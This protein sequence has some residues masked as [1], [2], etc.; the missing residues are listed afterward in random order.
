LDRCGQRA[1]AL[2]EFERCRRVLNEDLGIDPSAQ[3]QAL[4]KRI[5]DEVAPTLPGAP[6]EA[7]GF[8]SK[9]RLPVPL[10]ALIGRERES[11]QLLELLRREDVRLVTLMGSPGIGKTRLAVAAAGELAAE[12]GENIYFLSLAAL[13]SPGLMLTA[14]AQALGRSESGHLTPFDR[15]VQT[16]Q[17][18]R[19][20]L[21]L[22]TFEQVLDAAPA[23][24]E[25]LQACPRLKILVTARA[26]LHLRGEQRFML[27]PLAL[28]DPFC[29]S[30]PE[31]L[32]ASPAV[33]LFVERAQAV[34]PEFRL[35]TRNGKAVA[36]ICMRLDGLPLAIE[37]AAAA[38]RLM[39]PQRLL[40]RLS[41]TSGS[42]LRLLNGPVRDDAIHHQ[43]LRQ[44]FQWSYNLLEDSA[45]R[46]FARLGVFVSGCTLEAIDAICNVGDIPP[47]S[48]EGIALLLDNCLVQ[49]VE[50]PDGEYRFTM[51]ST[52]REFALDRLAA[53]GE[54]DTLRQRHAD[55]YLAY[56]RLTENELSV[57]DEVAWLERV[58]WE[59]D[60]LRAA[61][62]W[63]MGASP[64]QALSL[65]VALFPFWHVRSY[66]NEG[67][68]YLE[69][70]LGHNL[71]PSALRGR[72]LAAAGL[73][74]QRQ[75]D[76]RQAENLTSESV[77]LYRQLEDQPGLAY[78][79]NNQA[80][81]RMS[82]GENAQA[83]RLAEESLA[84][85]QKLEDVLGI[86]RAQMI[87][88]QIALNEDRLD[89]A[90]QALETSLD[91]WRRRGDSKNAILC[92]IN[93]GRVSMVK[94]SYPQA[95][96][97]IEES[98]SL[99]RKIKDPHWEMVG[100][101]NLAEITLCQGAFSQ[102]E[103]LLA[104]CLDQARRLGDRYFE[105]VTL[106]R[107]GLVS[108]SRGPQG[109]SQTAHLLQDSLDVGRR[110]GSKWI[111][112]DALAHLGYADL[113]NGAYPEADR[114][115]KQS[116]LL[117]S[118]QGECSHV[119]LNMERLAIASLRQAHCELAARLLAAASA[120]RAAHGEPLP[121]VYCAEQQLA[122]D[123][124][125]AQLGE[126]AW[127]QA[128]MEGQAMSLDQALGLI[129]QG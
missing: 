67:R 8:S 23:L 3:T 30:D 65:A 90:R 2:A 31:L 22:D 45:Q 68:R 88:G 12:F 103:P 70:A 129:S 40:E 108:L 106:S 33:K 114:Q 51:L 43:T 55:Y 96:A 107:Q 122:V 80:I 121:P 79:L 100:L 73:L 60:N 117:F 34:L 11:A 105:A 82:V 14:I 57:Q 44:A 46:L 17:S 26:P 99:S 119:V 93:L 61:L 98:L 18:V 75:G 24:S 25:I 15:L 128:W 39:S 5:H 85:C 118:E 63:T 110:T 21:I 113:L 127:T 104:G 126:G 87:S 16:F 101:W 97:L 41:G 71:M 48:V 50:S 58:E 1:A 94:G 62:D 123:Q 38:V 77:S 7:A 120:W 37:L 35:T 76:F 42:S 92:L 28:P 6:L 66:L 52:L 53:G 20:M 36:A 83:L 27:Y 47:G 111:V 91:F 59:L 69:R 72:A 115:L 112:A 124:L 125:R 32:L 4:Y 29:P 102:A 54:W 74:A 116:L 49:R 89:A 86:A 10:T 64:E 19:A 9:P 56:A 109:A 81:V 95:Q 13:P 78:A 84:L